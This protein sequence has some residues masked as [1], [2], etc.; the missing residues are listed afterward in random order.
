MNECSIHNAL[1]VADDDKSSR[2]R[3][4]E[5]DQMML[6][7]KQQEQDHDCDENTVAVISPT[8]G[9][10]LTHGFVSVIG[11]RREMEDAVAIELGFL[12]IDNS[13]D[14]DFFGVYDGHGGS[15]VANSCQGRLH[16]LLVEECKTTTSSSSSTCF[17][18]EIWSRI[19]IKCF[20]KMDEEV[21]SIKATSSSPVTI[22][23]TAVVAVVG[24]DEV[25][26]A[27]CGDSRAVLS[28][29]G[30]PLSISNDHKPDRP[31]ELER[32]ESAGG[33]VIDWDGHRVL[34]VLATSRSIGDEYLQPYVI[35]EPEVMITKRTNADEF[36]ILATDG[37]WDVVSNEMA[38]LAVKR[39]LEGRSLKKKKKMMI[40]SSSDHVVV[41][42]EENV[43][44]KKYGRAQVAAGLLVELAKSR[45]SKDNITVVVVDLN[46]A[47]KKCKVGL[48]I[49]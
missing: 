2:K 37:L 15:R 28:R 35:P 24:E 21:N 34:G 7:D 13:R 45:G 27:N 33:K 38:C 17:G 29:G 18:E 46:K 36:L 5:K 16:H 4:L 40:R 49:S 25:V 32:I 23:S 47:R 44:K 8:R 20:L 43:E 41:M 30:I 22:G 48:V 1:S 9:T 11:R 6:L 3:R 19:M 14:Y 31:D 12:T 39:I 26:V 10:F 42:Q